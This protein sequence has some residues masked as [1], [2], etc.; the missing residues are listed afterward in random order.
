MTYFGLYRSLSTH[1]FPLFLYNNIFNLKTRKMKTNNNDIQ[2]HVD[3]LTQQEEERSRL[4]KKQLEELDPSHDHGAGRNAVIIKDQVSY[5]I[6]KKRLENKVKTTE[7]TYAQIYNKV[8]GTNDPGSYFCYE[9]KDSHQ[10]LIRNDRDLMCCIR[11]Y[12]ATTDKSIT[13]MN[14]RPIDVAD[15]TK[16]NFSNEC[17]DMDGIHFK[18]SIA[19]RNNDWIF[20]SLKKNTTLSEALAQFKAINPAVTKL[21]FVDSDKDIIPISSE[22]EWEYF[23]NECEIQFTAGKFILLSAE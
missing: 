16:L 17:I 6:D 22:T 15:I 2:S 7:A 13:F 19:G 3:T 5:L 1:F 20:S 11:E 8:T 14:I 18:L 10:I 9:D 12:F 23:L 4:L 21:H